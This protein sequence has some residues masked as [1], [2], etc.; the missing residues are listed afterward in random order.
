[1]NNTLRA[2]ESKRDLRGTSAS[3]TK[4]ALADVV[5]AIDLQL[6]SEASHADLYDWGSLTTVVTDAVPASGAD[7]LTCCQKHT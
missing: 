7:S 1:M 4:L 5:T 3:S 2:S 6:K